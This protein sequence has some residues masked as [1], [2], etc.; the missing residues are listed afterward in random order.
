[1]GKH[2]LKTTIFVVSSKGTITFTAANGDTLVIEHEVTSWFFGDEGVDFGF[3]LGGTWTV[4]E[5]KGP[6]ASPTQRDLAR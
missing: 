4:D 6:V 2:Y 3:T 1:M 5:G